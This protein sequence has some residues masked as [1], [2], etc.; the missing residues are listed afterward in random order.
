[1]DHIYSEAVRAGDDFVL[2]A[3]DMGD[4]DMLEEDIVPTQPLCT[5]C[6]CVCNG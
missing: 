4:I 5:G 6:N 1:M 3:I 2:E